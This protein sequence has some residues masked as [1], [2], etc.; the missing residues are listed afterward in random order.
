MI[1]VTNITNDSNQRHVVIVNEKEVFLTLRFYPVTQ[2]WFFDIEYEGVTLY[3]IK[4]SLGVRH[5]QGNNLP[6][7]IILTDNSNTGLDPFKIDDFSNG[8]IT[9]RFLDHVEL[10][11]LRGYPVE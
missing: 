9:L 11:A 6:F 10:T 4:A 2:S 7:E 1:R 5:L 3:G 8:R